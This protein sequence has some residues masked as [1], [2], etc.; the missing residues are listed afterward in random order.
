MYLTILCCTETL[1]TIV[2]GRVSVPSPQGFY[3]FYFIESPVCALKKGGCVGTVMI[4]SVHICAIRQ[5][6]R[7][8]SGQ[9]HNTIDTK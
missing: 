5:T 4:S 1:P 3:L 7:L 2:V 6:H 8:D 9:I